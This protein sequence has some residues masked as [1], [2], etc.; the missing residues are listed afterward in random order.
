MNLLT[1]NFDGADG[2]N[3]SGYNG[4]LGS[5]SD[6]IELDTAVYH[7]GSAALKIN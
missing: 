4:W 2:T 3:L 1:E 6:H 7:A 5:S